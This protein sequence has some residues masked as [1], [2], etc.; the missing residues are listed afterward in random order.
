MYLFVLLCY[1]GFQ[2]LAKVCFDLLLKK[3]KVHIITLTLIILNLQARELMWR[4][5]L[6]SKGNIKTKPP[7]I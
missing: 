2:Q 4:F 7:M 6:I 1:F 3:H 5:F